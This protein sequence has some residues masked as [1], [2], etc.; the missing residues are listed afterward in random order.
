MGQN[1]LALRRM[2]ASVD[3]NAQ[4]MV[5]FPGPGSLVGNYEGN[6]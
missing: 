4:Q 3:Q 1:S 6:K 2:C 5:L